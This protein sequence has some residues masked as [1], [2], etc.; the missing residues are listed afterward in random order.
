MPRHLPQILWATESKPASN[1]QKMLGECLGC[2]TDPPLI[3]HFHPGLNLS[4]KSHF[5]YLEG[6]QWN[7]SNIQ[8]IQIP[9]GYIYEANLKDLSLFL[10]SKSQKWFGRRTPNMPHRLYFYWWLVEC[11][12]IDEI[13]LVSWLFWEFLHDIIFAYARWD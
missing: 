4:L 2:H 12:L 8:L 6:K 3:V 7:N 5:P 11:Y 10:T 1:N 9:Q 13:G